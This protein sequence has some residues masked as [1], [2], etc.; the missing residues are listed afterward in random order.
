MCSSNGLLP[1]GNIG[2]GIKN[3]YGCNLVPK[4]PAKITAFIYL[5]VTP[6]SIT[7]GSLMGHIYIKGEMLFGR[8]AWFVLLIHS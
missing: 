6:P 1:K 5:G 2:L 3:V 4:P 8:P 7:C